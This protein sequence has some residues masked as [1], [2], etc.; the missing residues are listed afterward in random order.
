M[1]DTAP[2]SVVILVPPRGTSRRPYGAANGREVEAAFNPT[3]ERLGSGPPTRRRCT[4]GCCRSSCRPARSPPRPRPVRLGYPVRRVC[5]AIPARPAPALR[6]R[7]HRRERPGGPLP[8]RLDRRPAHPHPGHQ[9]RQGRPPSVTRAAPLRR[10]VPL[11]RLRA[12]RR[13]AGPAAARHS[14]P[15]RLC[16]CGVGRCRPGGAALHG[17]GHPGAPLGPLAP[18]VVVCVGCPATRR[19]PTG[20]HFP[21]DRRE[22]TGSR[23]GRHS[24]PPII[25]RACPVGRRRPPSV[26]GRTRQRSLPSARRIWC[27]GWSK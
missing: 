23:G 17:S 21:S 18:D 24:W 15:C 19:P 13:R 16:L 5:S 1:G 22:R 3:I 12:A 8:H 7:L 11:D 2:W 25:R 14:T 6:H 9:G 4:S 27:R 26:A 20:H 10:G